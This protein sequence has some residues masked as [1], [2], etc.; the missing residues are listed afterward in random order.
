MTLLVFIALFGLAPVPRLVTVPTWLEVV[1][2][3]R[4][5]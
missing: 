5:H 3:G 2:C 4:M 1:T